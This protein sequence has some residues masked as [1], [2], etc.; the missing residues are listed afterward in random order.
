M[1]ELDLN[2]SFVS[3][4]KEAKDEYTVVLICESGAV[5]DELF[6]KL[7]QHKIWFHFNKDEILIARVKIKGVKVNVPLDIPVL[8]PEQSR[9]Y[10]E[11]LEGKKVKYISTGILHN[12]FVYHVGFM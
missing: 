10:I 8:K 6:K 7:I 9:Q 3:F 5:V 1:E 12:G 2:V 11:W 4:E